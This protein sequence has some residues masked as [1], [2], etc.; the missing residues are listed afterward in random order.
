MAAACKWAGMHGSCMQMGRHACSCSRQSPMAGC[1]WPLLPQKCA[2]LCDAAGGCLLGCRFGGLGCRP[3]PAGKYSN[4]GNYTTCSSCGPNQSSPPQSPGV[5]YCVCAAG[6]GFGFSGGCE[7]CPLGTFWPGPAKTAVDI[8]EGI[9]AAAAAQKLKKVATLSACLACDTPVIGA[10]FTTL[11]R[12]ATSVNQCVC[13]PGTGGKLC[14]ICRP[15]TYSPGGTTADCI[16]CGG[17]GTTPSD[18]STSPTQCGC[19]PGSGGA[20]CAVSAAAM[21]CEQ[22][23]PTSMAATNTG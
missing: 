10:T 23:Q 2:M 17:L 1:P 14:G 22:F 16:A 11:Q 19:Q 5:E 6:Y 7:L 12:G 18:A 20:N 4:G 8:G 3:C 15:G 13:K 9:Q 21:P